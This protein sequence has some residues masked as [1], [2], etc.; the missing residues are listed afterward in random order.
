MTTQQIFEKRGYIV[1]SADSPHP[2]GPI[3]AGSFT[4]SN[5]EPCEVT[6]ILVAETDLADWQEQKRLLGEEQGRPKSFYYRCVAE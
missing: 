2:L 3:D 6:T 5:F 1:I 4:L